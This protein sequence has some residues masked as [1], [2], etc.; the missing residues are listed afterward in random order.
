VDRA[1]EIER[2][3]LPAS[4]VL[5][6]LAGVGA[7][8]PIVAAGDDDVADVEDVAGGEASAGLGDLAGGDADRL[9]APVQAKRRLA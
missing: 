2:C 9:E 7:Q 4:S 1:V 8:G 6:D 3:H 5:H